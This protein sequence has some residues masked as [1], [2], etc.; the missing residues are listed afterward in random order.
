MH[1]AIDIPDEIASQLKA[2]S[3]ELTKAVLEAVAVESYRNGLI[4]A[5]QVQQML[6]LTSRWDVEALLKQAEAF[7]DYTMEDLARDLAAIRG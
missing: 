1:V 7:H 6:G 4:T 2:R 3:G 5:G